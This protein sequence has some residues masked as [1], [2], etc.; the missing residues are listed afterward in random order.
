[1]STTIYNGYY[2]PN[3]SLLELKK[4]CNKLD[5]KRRK[6]LTEFVKEYFLKMCIT[7]TD[8]IILEPKNNDFGLEKC[9]KDEDLFS[10][11]FF[12]FVQQIKKD[13]ESKEFGFFDFK[14]TICFIPQSDKILALLYCNNKK[15]SDLFIS[16]EIVSEYC[17]FNNTDKPENISY[18]EWKKRK[19]EW[20][21]ALTSIGDNVNGYAKPCDI[22]L[23]YEPDYLAPIVCVDHDWSVLFKDYFSIVN[24]KSR[25]KSFLYSNID[26]V[27][28]YEK[29]VDIVKKFCNVFEKNFG[30]KNYF[31]TEDEIRNFFQEN[32]I[33]INE[34]FFDNKELKDVKERVLNYYKEIIN[35]YKK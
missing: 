7:F 14:M 4:F 19:I 24:K 18:K 35:D 17:Y 6:V 9:L 16:N 21:N 23:L 20:E 15:L 12:K 22:G 31:N 3:M 10:Y 26:L 30:I 8:N 25:A 33:D 28:K 32:I 27:K 34:S 1:M 5:I 11:L 2:L 13:S 29:N